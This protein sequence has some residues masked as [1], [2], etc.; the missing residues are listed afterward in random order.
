MRHVG[1]HLPR[2]TC[3]Y[4]TLNPK[5]ISSLSTYCGVANVIDVR[6]GIHPHSLW[7]KRYELWRKRHCEAICLALLRL[8]PTAAGLRALWISTRSESSANEHADL[9]LYIL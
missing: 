9:L 4:H 5:P 6:P 3:I 1:M 2:R 7:R 8:L